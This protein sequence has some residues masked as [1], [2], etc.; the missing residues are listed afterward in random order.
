MSTVAGRARWTG[1]TEARVSGVGDPPR[2]RNGAPN[3]VMIVLDDLG[4]ADLGCYGSAIATPSIDS[5]A[6]EGLRYNN[7]HVTAVCTG[8]RACLLTGRNHH[9]VGMGGGQVDIR[10]YTNRIPKSAGTVARLLRDA[11]YNTFAVGKWHLTPLNEDTAAGPFDR[12]PLGLGFER[13]YGFL[14]G[15]TSQ[16]TPSLVCDNNFVEPLR[17]PE[18]DYH[19][20]EDLADQAIRLVRNQQLAKPGKPFFLY[21][22]TGAAHSPHHVRYEWIEPYRNRF[23][24][25][26]EVL[27]QQ[28][29]LRQQKLGVVPDDTTLTDRPSWVPPW[30][31]LSSDEHR[32]FARMMEVYAGF[33]THTD[34]QIGRILDFLARIDILDNTMVMILSDN[35]A[36]G[37]GGPHGR[38]SPGV[39]DVPSMMKRIDDFGGPHAWNSYAWGWAWAGN[40]PFKLWKSYTWL[41]GV[42]VPL[43]VRWP[44]GIPENSRRQVRTQFCHAID[45]M[46]TI[47]DACGVEPPEV[48]DGV[49]Q[50]ALDGGSICAS[51]GNAD[52]PHLRNT[53]YF[54]MMGS[55]AIY[56]DGWKATTNHVKDKAEDR[57]LIE[58]SHDFDEDRWSLFQLDNDFSEAHDLAEEHPERLRMLID[59]WWHEADCNHIIP[60]MEIGFSGGRIPIE[61]W[62]AEAMARNIGLDRLKG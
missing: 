29:F 52:H 44:T 35:G 57:Q 4:F 2:Q 37:D 31:E 48:L 54:E 6:T 11:G 40:T 20:T 23:D 12:W 38:I 42:R 59:L 27:R 33:I 19:L 10:G 15:A 5:L 22:A 36:S 17:S 50:Q 47:L 60:L 41:G 24:D 58:G 32:V 16:W 62:V 56:H 34:A 1:N 46:P 3:V 53:Q 55:R 51:F 25:G 30:R 9:A 28:T 18:Q 43:V 39:S 45:L 26:W 8:T 61:P 49:D 14:G 13:Y 7:F 21:F